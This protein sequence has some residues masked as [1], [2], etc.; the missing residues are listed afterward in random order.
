MI[1]L[2]LIIAPFLALLF[3]AGLLEKLLLTFGRSS[4]NERPKQNQPHVRY[5]K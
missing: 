3:V 5:K 4:T 2:L 1:A